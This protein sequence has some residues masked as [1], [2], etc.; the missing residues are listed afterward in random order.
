[1]KKNIQPLDKD[2][3]IKTLEKEI[4]EGLKFIVGVTDKIDSFF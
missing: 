1:M 4:Y 2:Q 3:D